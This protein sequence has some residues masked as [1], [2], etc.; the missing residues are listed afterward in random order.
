M[1]F[2]KLV[3]SPNHSP[4]FNVH[5]AFDLDNYSGIWCALIIEICSREQKAHRSNRILGK[6]C[7][8]ERFVLD[9]NG[10]I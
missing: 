2:S 9:N 6:N 4:V 8:N 3:K 1:F 7:E 10:C 5:M